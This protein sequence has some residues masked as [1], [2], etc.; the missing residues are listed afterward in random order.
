MHRHLLIGGVRVS[1]IPAGSG[2]AGSS[3]IGNNERWH[4]AAKLK[5]VDVRLN[6]RFHLL[7][8]SRLGIRVGTGP[9]DSD[10]QRCLSDQ[11][12]GAIVNGNLRSGPI[13]EQ[14]L[15]RLVLLP[16]HYI[17]L[18][19]PLLILVAEVAVA[20]TIRMRLP[21]FH[22]EELQRQVPVLAELIVNRWE[23]QR[24]SMQ[25]RR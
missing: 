11:T 4:T 9:Q 15:A 1:I 14:L 16:E 22:P 2:D 12:G 3:I 5:S 24:C 8:A 19:P 21:V 7:I 10:E 25:W 13:D 20:V 6:P 17:E 18:A 23:I